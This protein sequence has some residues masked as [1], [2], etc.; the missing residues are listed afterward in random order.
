MKHGLL[1]SVVAALP[2]LQVF[3]VPLATCQAWDAWSA[4][5]CAHHQLFDGSTMCAWKRTFHGPNALATPLR[6]YY[7]PRVP[8]CGGCEGYAVECGYVVGESAGVCDYGCNQ[9]KMASTESVFPP[10][11]GFAPAQFERLGQLR[12]ELDVASPIATPANGT[13]RGAAGR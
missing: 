7:I 5:G 10:E 11:A 2:L 3:A 12:N 4:C 6:G 9:E 13:S 8:S 1:K